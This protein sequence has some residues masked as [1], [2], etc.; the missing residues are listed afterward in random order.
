MS[1][2]NDISK[3]EQKLKKCFCKIGPKTIKPKKEKKKKAYQS[4]GTINLFKK[5]FILKKHKVIFEKQ[6]NGEIEKQIKYAAEHVNVSLREFT[7]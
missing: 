7:K 3:V 6:S 2:I 1:L 4:W 5:Y